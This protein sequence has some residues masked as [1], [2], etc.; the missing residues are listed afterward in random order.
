MIYIETV[1]EN[2]KDLGYSDYQIDEIIRVI[3]NS[4]E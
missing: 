2:L 3:M 1:K 4:N